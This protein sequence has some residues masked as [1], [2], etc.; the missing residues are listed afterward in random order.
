MNPADFDLWLRD[1]ARRPLLMGVLNVTPD[2]F[3]DGGCFDR[4]EAAAVR[5]REMVEQGAAVIDVGGESTRPGAQPVPADEQIRR[6]VPAI[7]AIRDL[8]CV[9]SIDTAD[10]TVAAAALDAGATMLNDV[11]AGQHDP[12]MLTLAASRGV[13]IALMHSRGDPKTMGSMTFYEDVVG[14]VEAFLLARARAAID[15]G[16]AANR[17]ILDVGIGFAKTQEQ[18]LALLKHHGRVASHGFATLLGTSRKGFIG[19]LTGVVKAEDRAFGTAATV[20]IGV[21]NGADLLRVH[22]VAEMR[23]VVAVAEAIRDA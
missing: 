22:D 10:A 14:E 17:V 21:A 11:T 23:Q 1:P 7:A 18:N 9:I 4:V 2:S 13:P 20:A 8:P 3:S 19:K 6:V 12:N 15:A 5:A 16:V